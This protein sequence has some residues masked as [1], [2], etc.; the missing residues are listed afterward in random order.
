[1]KPLLGTIS[2]IC[3]LVFISSCHGSHSEPDATKPTVS[4]LKPTTGDTINLNTD[5][6]KILLTAE[7]NID[8]HEL[9]IKITNGSTTVLD[10]SPVV[11]A[12]KIYTFA[13][14]ILPQNIT[15][16]T[17]L[18][19]TATATDHSENVGTKTVNFFVKK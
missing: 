6:V 17:A 1:M 2:V 11:H 18:T 7:D 3:L 10:E 16:T 5:S 8:L 19:L 13:K 12:Q 15:G 4:V 9:N 14:I